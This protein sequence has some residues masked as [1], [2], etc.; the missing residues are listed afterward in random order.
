VAKTAPTNMVPKAERRWGWALL[1]FALAVLTLFV[2][3]LFWDPAT[4]LLSSLQFWLAVA[5]YFA[6]RGVRHLKQRTFI[7]LDQLERIHAPVVLLRPFDQDGDLQS[8]ARLIKWTMFR[9][10]LLSLES[11]VRLRWTFE[12]VLEHA[13]REIGPLVAVGP[14]SAPPVLGADNLF[15]NDNDWQEQ[16]ASIAARA[17][18]VVMRAASRVGEGLLW[19]VSKMTQCLRPHQLLLYIPEGERR[20]WFP[21]WGK[22]S[23]RTIYA[24]FRL[25]TE[26]HFKV[27]LPES[28]NGAAFIAFG[29][30]WQPILLKPR[31]RPSDS[32]SREY[33]AYMVRAVV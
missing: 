6:F 19:E 3:L 28:L 24:R 2:G 7:S 1:Y 4:S 5:A 10:P 32:K 29:P 20:P 18:L 13:T 25:E 23:R 11:V 26:G 30:D 31:R 16:V 22:G 27:A 33:V 21:A 8:G 15:M 12:Q 17:E 14:R 9:H